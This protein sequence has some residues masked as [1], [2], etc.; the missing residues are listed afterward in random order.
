MSYWNLEVAREC[1]KLMAS[2]S[3]IL[4]WFLMFAGEMMSMG[5]SLHKGHM[6]MEEEECWDCLK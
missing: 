1:L 2:M 4:L 6:I 3:L 5:N